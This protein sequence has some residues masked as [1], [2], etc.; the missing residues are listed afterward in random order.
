M[1]FPILASGFWLPG[2]LASFLQ[3]VQRLRPRL[4]H[5]DEIGNH[6][7]GLEVMPACGSDSFLPE[8]RSSDVGVSQFV[9][10]G[11]NFEQERTGLQPKVGFTIRRVDAR[12]PVDISKY[13]PGLSIRVQTPLRHQAVGRETAMQWTWRMYMAILQVHCIAVSRPTAWWRSGVWT[14]IDRPGS[15]FEISTGLRASTRRMVNP[16]F[17]WRP[18]RSCS[19]FPPTSTN[20]ETPTS[21]ERSSGRNE[22]EPH[23]GITSRPVT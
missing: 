9:D 19:K 21:L 13:D 18:V 6:V 12:S 8:L 3:H 16:T 7:T 2:F 4:V 10:V 1:G 17:G 23:A 11:G 22:S 15:Y 14:R 5:Q 20:C